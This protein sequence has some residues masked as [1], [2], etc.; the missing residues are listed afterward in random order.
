MKYSI[1]RHLTR[2]ATVLAL[3]ELDTTDHP[4]DAVLEAYVDMD[5]TDKDARVEAYQALCDFQAQ[6]SEAQNAETDLKPFTNAE[7]GMFNRLTSGAV[8]HRSQ[9]DRLIARYAPEWPTEQ[10]AVID[11]SVL[12][13]AIYEM[14][15][16]DVPIK[17]VINEAVEIA[18]V[19]GGDSSPR[20]INGVLGAIVDNLDEI[21]QDE[22][23]LNENKA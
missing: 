17:V 5:L 9:A 20:F 16:E 7:I 21:L 14:L 15:H 18:K 11:R 23:D 22:K 13:V 8:E 4:Q 6:L 1:R 19:F 3:Y 10:I 12:R 2:T